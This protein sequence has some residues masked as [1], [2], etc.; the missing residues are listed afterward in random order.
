M[1]VTAKEGLKTLVD[2]FGLAIGLRV[3]SSRHA[4]VHFGQL[5]EFLLKL[6][7]ED[8]VSVRHNGLGQAVKLEDIGEEK[9]GHRT[10]S[11]R[12]LQSKEVGILRKGVNHDEDAINR[13]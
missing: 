10:C 2:S 5:E 13:P 11:E 12:M 6:A 4:Q 8:A 9:L 1:R 7:R 3:I